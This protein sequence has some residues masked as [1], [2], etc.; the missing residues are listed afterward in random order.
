MKPT[1]FSRKEFLQTFEQMPLY[2]VGVTADSKRFRIL[3]C[4]SDTVTYSFLASA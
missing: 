1:F 3:A 4:G 2:P